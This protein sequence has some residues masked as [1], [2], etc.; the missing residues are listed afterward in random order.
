MTSA[1]LTEGTMLDVL[2]ARAHTSA[3]G[4]TFLDYKLQPDYW[5]FTRLVTEA[6][7]RAVYFASRGLQPGE[8]FAIMVPD[9]REF[10]LSFFGAIAAGL[11]PVPMY[12][13][14]GPRASAEFL[15]TASEIIEVTQCRMLLA[16]QVPDELEKSLAY[17]RPS[18]VGPSDPCFLQFTSGSTRAPKGV[19]VS[20][21]NL[22]A[23]SRAIMEDGLHG[24]PERDRGVCWL[25]LYHDMGLIGHVVAPFAMGMSVVFIPTLAFI[26][27]PWV[28]ME[29]VHQYRCTI[30]FGPNF[31]LALA[32][33]RQNHLD[34]LE[35]SCLRVLGC[36]A[37]PVHADTLRTFVATFEPY[38]LR[39][40]AVMPCYGLAEA[41]LAV[42]FESLAR[43]ARI[44]A[45]DRHAYESAGVVQLT[46]AGAHDR[47]E[48][49]SCGRPL[50]GHEIAIVDEQG[51]PLPEGRVGEIAVRGPSVTP[52]YFRDPEASAA[53]RSGEWLLAG[54]CGFLLD[55]DLFVSGRKK[56]LLIV[57]GR[58]YY[59]QALEWVVEELPDVR[60]GGVVAFSV[61]GADSEQVIVVAETKRKA[62]AHTL[63]RQIRQHLRSS[64]GLMPADVVLIGP[65]QLPK[66]SSGKLQRQKAK[67]MYSAGGFTNQ[68][69]Q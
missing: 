10:V 64:V 55:S 37:E 6:R 50:P 61:P 44:I 63:A 28:W 38:G 62:E 35:L 3:H 58:N 40:E 51:K 4:F 23:N 16:D 24:D 60:R 67:Q 34:R 32:V 17:V 49:A 13:A 25:P 9:V 47:I 15:R 33:K 5:S 41:T 19:V 46:A 27:R 2:E 31:A 48:L 52:G 36:G 54:D 29:T 59:P 42:S 68:V 69:T 22:L 43:P 21:A 14:F 8:R 12:P 7:R 20:H 11:V 30:T 45:I 53:Q 56:D 57:D 1:M 18:A 65:G 66:T 26:A 39:P